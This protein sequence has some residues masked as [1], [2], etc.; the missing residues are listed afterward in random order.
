MACAS[1]EERREWLLKMKDLAY[2]RA[3]QVLGLVPPAAKQPGGDPEQS[4]GGRGDQAADE[5]HGGTDG[6]HS[7]PAGPAG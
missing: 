3:K 4:C 1:C 7:L 6:G 5:S 2:E